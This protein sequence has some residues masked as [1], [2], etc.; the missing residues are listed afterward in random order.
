MVSCDSDDSDSEDSYEAKTKTNSDASNA[1]SEEEVDC[2]AAAGS[3]LPRCMT[4]WSLRGS[5]PSALRAGG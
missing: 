5:A 2:N 3:H 1:A 4:P